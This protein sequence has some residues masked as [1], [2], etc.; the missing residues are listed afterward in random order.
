MKK[1]ALA[2]VFAVGSAYAVSAGS[3]EPT[4]MEPKI[5]EPSVIVEEASSSS[6]SGLLVPIMFAIFA[7][8]VAF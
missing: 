3:I 4:V 1:V 6:S 2:A 5:M 7:A 8:T